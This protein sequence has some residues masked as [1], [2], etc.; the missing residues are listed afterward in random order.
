MFNVSI[1]H[2]SKVLDCYKT[3]EI[4]EDHKFVTFK[5]KYIFNV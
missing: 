2:I 3:F 4:D 1:K 5:L